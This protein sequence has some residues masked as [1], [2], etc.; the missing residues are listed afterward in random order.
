MATRFFQNLYYRITIRAGSPCPQPGTPRYAEHYRRIYLVVVG[1]YLLFTVY[2]VDW[3]L[4][5]EG[6]LY[7]TLGV[8]PDANDKDL[9]RRYR[10]LSAAM[11]P[12]KSGSSFDP[13]T[14]ISLQ[15]AHATL[16]DGVRRFAYDRL[17][18]SVLDWKECIVIR[19]FIMKGAMGLFGYYGAGAA[20]LWAFPRLGYFSE[21]IYWR[22]MAFLALMVFEVRTITSP[23]FPAFLQGLV[24]PLLVRVI[25]PTLG[26]WIP[27]F[28][29][30]PFLPFQAVAIARKLS[31][32][33]S[34]ALN[35][36]MPFLTADTRGGRVQMRRSGN[37]AQRANQSLAELEKA[38]QMM[39]GE[40]N[41]TMQMEVTPFVKD[42][43]KAENLRLK[44]KRW[45]V[46]NTVRN[47]PMTK[48]AII[49]R[50]ARRRADAPAGALG[51]G[52]RP[53]PAYS[54]ANEL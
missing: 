46:D 3:D 21:G 40:A 43:A 25:N 4:Q 9:K 37:E 15:N 29:H 49:Q 28:A 27:G 39:A 52:A 35:Q 7:R 32:T 45:L 20:M 12:D 6:D 11:H 8:L 10:L 26:Y 31:I 42:A 23:E 5:R 24:N 19:D 30:P 44:M 47:E 34:I 51:N 48:D 36:V 41:H 13:M 17:G 38:L 53:R 16:T 54:T 1:L 50:I 18:P 2:E 22:W 14:Y 33:L